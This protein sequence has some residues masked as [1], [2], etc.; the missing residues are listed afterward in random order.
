MLV[1]VTPQNHPTNTQK[2][3]IQIKYI[4]S[5]AYRFSPITWSKRSSAEG[6]ITTEIAHSKKSVILSISTAP[7][8]V[9]EK[10]EASERTI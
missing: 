10:S 2:R 3:H 5:T 6:G 1:L 8:Y 9:M 7:S 4:P